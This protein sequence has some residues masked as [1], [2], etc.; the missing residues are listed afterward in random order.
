[1]ID[2]YGNYNYIFN[3]TLYYSINR[4]S[5]FLCKTKHIRLFETGNDTVRAHAN[6][7]TAYIPVHGTCMALLVKRTFT[8]TFIT[9]LY[10]LCKTLCVGFSSKNKT[11]RVE[12][13]SY[14]IRC[15]IP[16]FYFCQ[17]YTEIYRKDL[18]RRS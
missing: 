2:D 8:F 4:L 15:S 7:H 10:R 13:F 11:F 17:I 3:D 1:M 12:Y 14:R 5:L 16:T 18:C 6:G 9:Q